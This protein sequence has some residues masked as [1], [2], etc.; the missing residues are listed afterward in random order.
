VLNALRAGVTAGNAEGRVKLTAHALKALVN[1]NPYLVMDTV[2]LQVDPGRSSD[3]RRFVAH[4]LVR[5]GDAAR[6]SG[7]STTTL[8]GWVN[9]VPGVVGARIV[10]ALLVSAQDVEPTVMVEHVASRLVDDPSGD[11]RDL[12]RRILSGDDAEVLAAAADAWAAAFGDPPAADVPPVDPDDPSSDAARVWRWWGIVPAECV[13]AWKAAMAPIVAKRGHPDPGRFDIPREEFRWD[14]EGPSPVPVE[15]LAETGGVEAAE[16]VASWT[17]D[18]D[19]E[20]PDRSRLRLARAFERATQQRLVDWS[21]QADAIVATLD[22]PLPIAYFL[23][24]VTYSQTDLTEAA[25]AIV[26][27]MVFVIDRIHT[28]AWS[29]LGSGRPR[30]DLVNHLADLT[31]KVARNQAVTVSEPAFEQLWAFTTTAA[32][33]VPSGETTMGGF[34]YDPTG[35][36]AAIN[37]PWG[38][39]L[40]AVLVLAARG[41]RDSGTAPTGL[42]GFLDDVQQ[43]TGT[44]ARHLYAILVDRLPLLNALAPQWFDT[45]IDYLIPTSNDGDIALIGVISRNQPTI[46]LLNRFRD[47]ILTLTGDHPEPCV[48]WLLSGAFATLPGYMITDVISAA[49]GH[50]DAAG[51]LCQQSAYHVQDEPADSDSLAIAVTWWQAVLDDGTL[52]REAL[53]KLGH[54]AFVTNIAPA[55]YLPLMRDTLAATGGVI[56]NPI[57]VAERW[58]TD[59]NPVASMPILHALLGHGEPWEQG[60]IASIVVDCLRAAA[61]E[62]LDIDQTTTF[63]S[64]RAALIDRGQFDAVDVTLST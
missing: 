19:N 4:H 1:D 59:A 39:S 56:D 61:S 16:V 63:M 14:P 26:A 30:S 31:S 3:A 44:A 6:S 40:E 37:E 22:D 38:R 32:L 64:L 10:S 43:V 9:P 60:Y 51:E 28:N 8:L 48:R 58:R 35:L 49:A 18:A 17:P 27:A 20:D 41:Y 36:T 47:R 29:G 45:N 62:S 25:D 53:Q 13:A 34:D 50:V 5:I 42:P 57:E 33:D 7:V 15:A 21:K 52:P 46:A 55:A 11:E 12:I 54:W 23:R 2:P 24:A